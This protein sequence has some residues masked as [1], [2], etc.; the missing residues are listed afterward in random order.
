MTETNDIYGF[1]V[2]KYHS[3]SD[4]SD[5]A[6]VECEICGSVEETADAIVDFLKESFEMNE[7]PPLSEEEWQAVRARLIMSG[8]DDG[9]EISLNDYPEFGERT[10]P[11]SLRVDRVRLSDRLVASIRNQ[12]IHKEDI[13]GE[14][15]EEKKTTGDF[16]T[17]RLP[18]R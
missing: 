15:G 11:C 16:G 7:E 9:V 5:Y 10:V 1:L 17:D 18:T 4:M 2:R 12:F 14:S 6:T 3:Y 8:M 13:H